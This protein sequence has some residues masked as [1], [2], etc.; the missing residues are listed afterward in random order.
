MAQLDHYVYEKT[1]AALDAIPPAERDGIYVVSF[2]V[3]DEEDD[4][5]R[6]TITVGF[7][8][9]AEVTRADPDA[10]DPV[11][12]ASSKSEARWNY[13]FWRQNELAVVCDTA[14]DPDGAA[15]RKSRAKE[16][17]LW[18]DADDVEDPNFDARSERLTGCRVR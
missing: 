16:K 1:R 6:P 9:E 12:A 15:I 10:A 11:R 3:Y 13:A 18:F 4:P 5:R 17:G 2:F 8:T 7:N 14:R